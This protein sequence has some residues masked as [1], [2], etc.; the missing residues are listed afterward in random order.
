MSLIA[1]RVFRLTI[2]KGY[3]K[4]ASLSHGRTSSIRNLYNQN[5]RLMHGEQDKAYGGTLLLQMTD[6][7]RLRDRELHINCACD[8]NLRTNR[9]LSGNCV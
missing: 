5:Q 7:R 1:P 2:A 8:T 9:S 4:T 6:V 3:V